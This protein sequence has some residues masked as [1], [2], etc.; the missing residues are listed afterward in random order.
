[1]IHSEMHTPKALFTH[2]SMIVVSKLRFAHQKIFFND[3]VYSV[4]WQT[5]CR[6]ETWAGGG[7]TEGERDMPIL[8]RG[9][10]GR[11]RIV[12]RHFEKGQGCCQTVW[13]SDKVADTP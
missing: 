10:G 6:H 13:D 2:I 12:A 5:Y 4:V 9:G 11:D 3:H 8:E 1:M 7:Q